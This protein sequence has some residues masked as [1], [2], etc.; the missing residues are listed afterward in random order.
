[1]R[2]AE[3]ATARKQEQDTRAEEAHLAA[4]ARRKEAA[5]A[6]KAEQDR[7]NAMDPAEIARRVRG[8]R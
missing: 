7:I 8:R 6:R 2:L 1:M 4:A 5:D 3:I